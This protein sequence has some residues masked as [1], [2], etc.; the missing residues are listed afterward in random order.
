MN[1]LKLSRAESIAEITLPTY[2]GCYVLVVDYEGVKE[3][4]LNRNSWRPVLYVGKAEYSI[5]TRV[6]THICVGGSGHS[7]LRHSIG[8]LLRE[9]Y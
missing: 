3:L 5:R 1:S 9:R 2:P 7:T 8:A 6:N 4:G